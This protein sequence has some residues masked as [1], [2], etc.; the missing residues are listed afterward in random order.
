MKGVE[1][2]YAVDTQD[3]GL[4]VDPELV[5]PAFQ[6]EANGQG[7]TGGRDVELTKAWRGYKGS[8]A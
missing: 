7:L 3:H 2:G 5:A 6:G 4:N 8:P 1:I